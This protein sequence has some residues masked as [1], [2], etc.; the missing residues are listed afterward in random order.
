MCRVKRIFNIPGSC[1]VPPPNVAATAVLMETLDQPIGPPVNVDSVEYLTLKLFGQKRKTLY[2]CVKQLGIEY[3]D[4]LYDAGID[5]NRRAEELSIV[6]WCNVIKCYENIKA[7][8]SVDSS[9]VILDKI[10]KL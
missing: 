5:G 7:K 2:N 10:K 4:L 3:I 9:T 1:F 6:E 8:I